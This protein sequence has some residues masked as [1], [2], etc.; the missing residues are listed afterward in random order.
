MDAAALFGR[1]DELGALRAL[2]TRGR[3]GGGGALV[4]RGDPGIGKSALLAGAT[5]NLTGATVIRS[6]G[7]EAELSMPYAALQRIGVSLMAYAGALAPRQ[8]QALRVAWGMDDG[9][10]PERYLV[11][12]G[13]LGLFAEAGGS[14]PVVCVVD[15]AHW[16][17]PESLDVLAFVARRL[18]AESTVLLF[19]VRDSEESDV[20][21]AGVPSLRLSGLDT[22]S[23][24]QLLTTQASDTVDP[25]AASQI[26]VAT[27]G[28]PLALIDL[29]RDLSIRQLGELSLSFDP[30][31]LS[32]KLEAHYL[33]Q[34]REMSSDVQ[35]WLLVAAAESTGEP[36]LIATAAAA[37]GLSPDCAADAERAGLVTV[38]DTVA[39]R[40][41]LVRSAVYG[42]ATGTDRRHTH[43]VLAN[44][45]R[46]LGLVELEA[47]HAAE[48]T[49]GLDDEVADRLESVAGLAARRG[50]RVSQARL[51][52]RSADLTP[53]SPVR[54]GRLLSAAEAAMD[55]G[56]AQL[57]RQ[58]LDRIE[59]ADLD[60]V[61]G[62]RLITT[63]AELALFVA[64]PAPMLRGP[65]DMLRAAEAFHGLA[66]DLEHKALRRAFECMFNT[67]SLMHGTDPATIGHR[68]DA[69][70]QSNDEPLGIVF[71]A[72]AAH[73]LQP[74]ATAVPLMREA[75]Q[76]LL[77]LPDDE[78]A[79]FGYVGI[80]LATALFDEQAG[81]CYLDRLARIARDSG[82]LRTLD[83]VLWV[84]SLFT[85]DH[86]DPAAGGLYMKQVRELRQAI[87]Y[88]AEHVV[89]VAYLAWTGAPRQ[90]VELFADATR[91]MGFGGVYRSA[92]TALGIRDIAEG[93]YRDAYTRLKP[94]IDPPFLQVTY[95]RLA[96]YVEA[97]V[98]SGHL[99][100]AMD[101]ART[102]AGMAA[103]SGTP[104]LRGLD[105]RC[106]ALLATDSAA[107][108]HYRE[109]IEVLSVANV[110]VDLGRSH[111]LYGE[112]LRRL[113]RRR[114][115]RTQL[116]A[117][118][119]ILDRAEAT[120]FAER[121]R[122]E[123]AATGEKPGPRHVVAG[124]EM[125]PQE[126]TIARMA[127]DGNTNAEIGAALFISS[128]TVD[129][130]LRKV[131]GKLGISSRR[132]LAKRL[133]TDPPS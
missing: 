112:W 19:A 103:A 23:A 109:A 62:G 81:D 76:L 24:V 5:A 39:F 31:P 124:V 38:R 131:F 126:A 18:Q 79:R 47:W 36:N 117:A 16:I 122:T 115:A 71:R 132:Q 90:Q 84:R 37:L 104:W 57:A 33:R 83:S 3:N 26:A 101:T 25:Y 49:P 28:N 51:L 127:A 96:D 65:A 110:P 46:R 30:V 43:G 125:S 60:S 107:E 59:P 114:D 42:A 80:I 73:L 119:D 118:V 54:N 97:S 67:D 116:R 86:G 11:G 92:T 111:L 63:R 35:Q 113:K 45:A 44:E 68:I 20:A 129:Y 4:V 108:D 32:R 130:H 128:N 40:H 89:N 72:M 22:R 61:Q 64:D 95:I 10:A 12:L 88:A 15:D 8:Q 82:A 66:P 91:S 85:V 41:P 17:D 77:A 106:R 87:G 52:A 70:A 50:G 93:H 75:M 121:A 53:P 120:A 9:P 34:V 123:L 13:M 7:F 74:Y 2:L 58:L 27:G 55:A 102:L 100:E 98:R 78:L 29:A 105:Q 94:M 1:A 69:A 48:A 133:A 56:A 99:P 14:R 21:L 6:D